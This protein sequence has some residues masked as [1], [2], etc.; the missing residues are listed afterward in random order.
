MAER[1]VDIGVPILQGT[2]AEQSLANKHAKDQTAARQYLR[3]MV[4]PDKAA[5]LLI[6]VGEDRAG[7]L[8][9][10]M[11]DEEIK[12]IS[13][14]MSQL[15]RVG[16]VAVEELLLEFARAFAGEGALVG[17]Y[18]GTERL[19]S[20]YIDQTRLGSI[21]EE[22]RGPAGRTI[23]E[24]L[25]NVNEQMLA[26]YLKNEHPQT[27]ALVMS[28]L[29]PEHTAKVL[30]ELPEGLSTEVVVRMLTVGPTKKD[31][32]I[33]VEE[34]LRTEFMQTLGQTSSHD[35]HEMMAEIFNG[36]DRPKESFFMG[37][38]DQYRRA[39]NPFA[40]VY[41]RGF[42]PA[43]YNWRAGCASNGRQGHLGQ[44]P[45]RRIRTAQ[46]PVPEQHVRARRKD[47]TRRYGG[48]GPFALAGRRG[49]TRSNRRPDQKSCRQRGSDDHRPQLQRR[50]RLLGPV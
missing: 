40:D 9:S 4:G 43:R 49:S 7:K 47:T 23:W 21:M 17:S 26:A 3:S 42:G 39:K 11:D 34:T 22:I 2:T 36:F 32:L 24:K 25:A 41:V 27:I 12:E 5:L 38:L 15:G 44:G 29:R 33:K 35:S 20:K 48:D 45:Q 50:T 1:E 19:L 14:S 8:L 31:V 10:R 13:K 18:E 28:K 16:S 6:A 30:A 46:K 37:A